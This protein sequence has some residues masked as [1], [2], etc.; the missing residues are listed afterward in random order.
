MSSEYIHI[1]TPVPHQLCQCRCSERENDDVNHKFWFGT[2]LNDVGMNFVS[3]SLLPTRRHP[4]CCC[5]EGAKLVL[6]NQRS[7]ASSQQKI[8][9]IKTLYIENLKLAPAWSNALSTHRV[10]EKEINI[11]PVCLVLQNSPPPPP[12]SLCLAIFIANVQITAVGAESLTLIRT[13]SQLSIRLWI[14][15]LDKSSTH[16]FSWIID[17]IQYF[18]GFSIFRGALAAEVQHSLWVDFCICCCLSRRGTLL[19]FEDFVLW[20]P[21]KF[22]WAD[23]FYFEIFI[24]YWS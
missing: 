16:T 10:D 2:P 7:L 4:G 8:E 3:C 20:K 24:C 15:I 5:G 18:E 9:N 17:W 22:Q 13:W 12:S 6:M 14:S 19:T 11:L 21:W 23:I 1:L